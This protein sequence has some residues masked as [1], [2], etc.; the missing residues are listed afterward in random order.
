MDNLGSRANYVENVLNYAQ[1]IAKP[2]EIAPVLITRSC[3]TM[4]GLNRIVYSK[5]DVS[6]CSVK[7]KRRLLGIKDIDED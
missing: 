6:Q 1:P 4:S 3:T 7:T 5:Q 2:A